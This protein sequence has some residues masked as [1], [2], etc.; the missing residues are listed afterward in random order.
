MVEVEAAD[1][2]SQKNEWARR[3]EGREVDRIAK[4]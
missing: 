2:K 1:R 3:V 4:P